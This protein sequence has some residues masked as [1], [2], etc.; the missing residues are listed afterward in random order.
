MAIHANFKSE[1]GF[2]VLSPSNKIIQEVHRATY[3][4][5]D[6][7]F[8]KA[9]PPFT[10]STLVNFYVVTTPPSMTAE[11]GAR[12]SN[13][14]LQLVTGDADD[15][16]YFVGKNV[17][18]A[19]VKPIKPT[20]TRIW[21][22]SNWSPTLT[23]K[24][25]LYV[26]NTVGEIVWSFELLKKAPYILNT[27]FVTPN[28]VYTLESTRNKRIYILSVSIPGFIQINTSMGS[29]TQWS[30]VAA[31]WSNNG[32][33]IT[34]SYIGENYP[35]AVEDIDRAGNKIPLIFLEFVN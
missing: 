16:I 12:A 8:K 20:Y 13:A 22:G 10:G 24:K 18:Y 30:G 6:T 14:D 21:A 29:V 1:D 4:Y 5:T 19:E 33:K 25:Y 3:P 31:K 2:D 11:E 15:Y 34:F 28:T 26:Q 27:V 23:D 17:I 7:T 9:I 32:S 35:K